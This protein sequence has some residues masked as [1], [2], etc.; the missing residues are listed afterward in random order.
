MQGESIM[1]KSDLDRLLSIFEAHCTIDDY[2]WN[3]TKEEYDS[4]KSKIESQ[5]EERI[6]LAIL[7]KTLDMQNKALESQI[8]KL[9]KDNEQLKENQEQLLS[10]KKYA[11]DEYDNLKQQ[12]E[13]Y[14]TVVDEIKKWMDE[15]FWTAYEKQLKL[16]WIISKLGSKE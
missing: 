6:T 11:W 1:T 13:Q 12:L 9:S 14:K 7:S 3:G 16:K 8:S 10:D 15:P 4:L 5:L 2:S